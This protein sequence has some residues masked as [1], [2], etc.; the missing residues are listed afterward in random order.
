MDLLLGLD[1]GTTSVKAGLFDASGACLAVAGEEYRLDH[2]GP[3][4]AE[5]DAES[6]W[7]AARA[8]I[9]RAMA[10]GGAGRDDV[11]ALAVSSQG[12]TVVPV[13]A[14]GRP[15]GPALVWLDN[16]A[17]AESREIAEAIGESRGYD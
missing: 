12:E 15:L 7:G 11:A 6:Y 5:L 4:R 14:A 1:V 13:D 16:R 9:R 8:A 3:D 10:A 17:L 2:P